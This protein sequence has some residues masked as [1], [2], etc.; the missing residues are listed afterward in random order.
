MNFSF[1]CGSIC[2]NFANSFQLQLTEEA[3]TMQ[4]NH[5]RRITHIAVSI[6]LLAWLTMLLS[7][8]ITLPP[9]AKNAHFKY[10]Q[11]GNLKGDYIKYLRTGI[12]GQTPDNSPVLLFFTN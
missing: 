8:L 11:H 9:I 6:I 10:A 12:P 5:A 1:I 4:R 2:Y 3:Y 7:L